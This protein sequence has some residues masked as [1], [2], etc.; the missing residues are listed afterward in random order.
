MYLY[1]FTCSFIQMQ[2]LKNKDSR[3]SEEKKIRTKRLYPPLLNV[4]VYLSNLYE[5]PNVPFPMF[6]LATR[7]IQNGNTYLKLFDASLF[8]HIYFA[9]CR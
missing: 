6:H 5:K 8:R 4:S 3:L 2:C 1:S 9:C 7:T